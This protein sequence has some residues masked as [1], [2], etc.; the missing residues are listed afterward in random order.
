MDVMKEMNWFWGGNH[1]AKAYATSDR[2]NKIIDKMKRSVFRN[3]SLKKHAEFSK[4]NNEL[5]LIFTVGSANVCEQVYLQLIGHSSTKMWQRC[6]TAIFSSYTRNNGSISEADLK[7]IDAAVSMKRHK[8]DRRPQPKA[9]SARSFIMYLM[10]FYASL[11]PNEG[12]EHI[13]ILPFEKLSQL[14]EEYRAHYK[15]TV[16]ATDDYCMASKETFRKQWSLVYKTGQVKL[17]RGKGTFPTCDIC[18][19]ANDMLTFSKTSRWTKRQR[20]IIISFKV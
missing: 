16:S 14:Y 6:K 7:S 5:H 18:N 11:S 9:D 8:T 13:R 1:T 19:N 10:Q 20:E 3:L 2:K 15:A 4:S 12:E 17:S